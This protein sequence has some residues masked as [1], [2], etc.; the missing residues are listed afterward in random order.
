MAGRGDLNSYDRSHK[1]GRF[2]V[3]YRVNSREKRPGNLME[4]YEATFFFL[5]GKST[6]LG[7]AEAMEWKGQFLTGLS[8]A[9][10]QFR[11]ISHPGEIK[12]S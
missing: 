10:E 4:N 7:L 11:A 12:A 1:S 5:P 6:D 9:T 3:E 8:S 2:L